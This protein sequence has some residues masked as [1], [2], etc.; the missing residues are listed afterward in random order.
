MI[1]GPPWKVWPRT[2]DNR[3]SCPYCAAVRA[4]DGPSVAEMW[5]ASGLEPARGG[6]QWLERMGAFGRSKATR[7][8]FD[9]E[10]GRR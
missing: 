10:E 3:C 5:E 8:V 6:D 1:E 9:R 4:G 7:A 2:E